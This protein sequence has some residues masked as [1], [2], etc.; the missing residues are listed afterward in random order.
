MN[1]E[2]VYERGNLGRVALPLG[3]V[4]VGLADELF[5][6][7]CNGEQ[8]ATSI[9]EIGGRTP[10]DI[11]GGVEET[12]LVFEAHDIEC[13]VMR[14][15]AVGALVTF[16]GK[17]APEARVSH[18]A[19][20]GHKVWFDMDD[21]ILR[22]A[23]GKGTRQANYREY[24]ERHG[25][26]PE[27]ELAR[28]LLGM[29]DVFARWDGLYYIEAHK[30]A[31]RWATAELAA[32]AEPPTLERVHEL[33]GRLAR[34]KQGIAEPGLPFAF[35]GN[36]LFVNRTQLESQGAGDIE[37]VFQPSYEPGIYDDVLHAAQELHAGGHDVGMLTLGDLTFQ[38]EKLARL[39]RAVQ[40]KGAW[41]F[42]TAAITLVP[43]GEFVE[44]LTAEALLDSVVR[45]QY[46]PKSEHT[47]IL[48][49]DDPGQLEA[50]LTR[51]ATVQRHFG[52]TLHALRLL[53]T[54]V[55]TKH[56]A[57][58]WPESAGPGRSTYL[59]HERGS[60]VSLGDMVRATL[61]KV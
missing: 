14:V 34:V 31:L 26:P 4:S 6:G 3:S 40:G 52:A 49:D 54:D 38:A 18:V 10:E 9:Q 45:D 58:A 22:Y 57:R 13:E 1:P 30:A 55:A 56:G 15:G 27:P 2:F 48:A 61:A 28:E 20:S 42:S 25:L 8:A 33:H 37:A 39:Y 12:R 16:A 21:S 35:G 5:G 53:R 19:P 50:F 32:S 59:W 7:L 51:A 47:L 36:R 43:K 60:A 17:S 41:P 29:T 23:M 46:F 44:G 11:V 24:L